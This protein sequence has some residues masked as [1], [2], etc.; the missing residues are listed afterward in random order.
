MI[1]GRCRAG[2]PALYAGGMF[3]KLGGR[4]YSIGPVGYVTSHVVPVEGY[5]GVERLG[6][7]AGYEGLVFRIDYEGPY[8]RITL[9]TRGATF[10]HQAILSALR[11]VGFVD[12]IL[13]S[14]IYGEDWGAVNSLLHGRSRLALLDV[15]G[16]VRVGRDPVLLRGSVGVVHG[17]S[18]EIQGSLPAY[19]TVV[20]DGP[21]RIRVWRSGNLLFETL[22]RGGVLR[23]PTGAG[24]S[25]S[26]ALAFYLLKGY[27]VEDAVRLASGDVYSLL[28]YIHD[29]LWLEDCRRI[30]GKV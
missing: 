15:Q 2:G 8:R 25:F 28:P 21:G 27:P 6:Y 10:D 9:L 18:D 14:P 20:T 23:D 16:Y 7:Q 19:Y 26:A 13:L 4:A 30:V 3:S 24:D 22:P 11:E 12:A 1:G 29:A 5:L 17:S